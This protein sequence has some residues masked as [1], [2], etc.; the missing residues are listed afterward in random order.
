MGLDP[1]V[2]HESLRPERFSG[3]VRV[4]LKYQKNRGFIGFYFIQYW[5][6]PESVIG[7]NSGLFNHSVFPDR[8]Y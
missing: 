5:V 8:N 2:Q 3:S 7:R 4:K 1:F 6:L